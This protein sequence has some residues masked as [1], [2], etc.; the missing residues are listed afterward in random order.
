MKVIF[1]ISTFRIT[2]NIIECRGQMRPLLRREES[3]AAV[4]ANNQL[5][6]VTDT[7][8]YGNPKPADPMGLEEPLKFQC[9]VHGE[10][11]VDGWEAKAIVTA[12]EP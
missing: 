7:E 8:R 12:A 3:Y 6:N 2:H 4:I 1:L 10:L 9:G 11:T 5:T